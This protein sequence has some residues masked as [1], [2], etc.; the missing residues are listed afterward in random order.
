M[1]LSPVLFLNSTDGAAA[2][3]NSVGKMEGKDIVFCQHPCDP[4]N[5]D[6]AVITVEFASSSACDHVRPKSA[7]ISLG[8]VTRNGHV[9]IANSTIMVEEPPRGQLKRGNA[10][11]QEQDF[12]WTGSRS[13][14]LMYTSERPNTRYKYLPAVILHEFGHA[15]GL[16][17]LPDSVFASYLMHV[18]GK[19]IAVPNQ[20]V[21][22]MKQVY[23][24]Y[25]N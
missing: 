11:P 14:H 8:T 4:P 6:Q 2:K 25:A 24:K 5:S 19:K 17:D 16:D 21:E 1:A 7:C 12:E 22:Y 15:L 9:H 13:L 18:A 3:W 20:D 10:P 23:T